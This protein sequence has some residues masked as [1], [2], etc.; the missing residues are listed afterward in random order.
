LLGARVVEIDN[1]V[2]ARLEQTRF[3]LGVVV[4]APVVVHVV[5]CEI[6]EYSDVK[7]QS[8]GAALAQRV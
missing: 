4:F 7:R 6:C 5:A 1:A 2:F 3:R 8:V